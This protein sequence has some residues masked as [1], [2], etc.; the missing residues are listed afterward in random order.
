MGAK[1][2]K[3]GRVMMRACA[4]EDKGTTGD[5]IPYLLTAGRDIGDHII[6]YVRMHCDVCAYDIQRKL[7]PGTILS[8][9]LPTL[10]EDGNASK[11]GLA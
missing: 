2:T 10:E 6:R 9:V 1:E 11:L 3:G 5:Y 8:R 4:A 7:H